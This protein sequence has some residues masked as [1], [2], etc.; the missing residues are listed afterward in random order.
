MPCSERHQN[1]ETPFLCAAC[2]FLTIDQLKNIKTPKANYGE[3]E[4]P[5]ESLFEWYYAYLE[6]DIKNPFNSD[7]VDLKSELERL[8]FEGDIKIL[9]IGY[10]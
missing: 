9:N 6:N 5:H 4:S 10:F 1:V 8:G 2:K 3:R 7:K